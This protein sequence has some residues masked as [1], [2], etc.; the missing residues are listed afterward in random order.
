[1]V[2]VNSIVGK[3]ESKAEDLAMAYGI[4]A[5][6]I[7]AG[8]GLNGAVS[9]A[10]DRLKNWK[11]PNLDQILSYLQDPSL[12]YNK[13]LKNALYAYLASIGLDVISQPRLSTAAEKVAWGLAKGT[14]IAAVLWLP[15]VNP[16]ETH[17][18]SDYTGNSGKAYAPSSY[19]NG[20][21]S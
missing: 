3:V 10:M 12:A 17:S 19:K 13:N 9:F 14:A 15:A 1:M 16:K 2:N 18:A 7:D 20:V 11:M 8:R 21:L 5:D 4:I 6:P